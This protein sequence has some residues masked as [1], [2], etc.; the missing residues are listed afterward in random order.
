[1]NSLSNLVTIVVMIILIQNAFGQH[2]EQKKFMNGYKESL[3]NYIMTGRE[4]GWYDCDVLSANPI[5]SQIPQISMDL[6]EVA[7]L[8]EATIKSMFASSHCL[9]VNYHINSEASLSA[10]MD[11]GQAAIQH[12]RLAMIIDL[13]SGIT[14]NM[15]KNTTKIPYPVAAQLNNGLEFLCPVVGELV[16]RFDKKFCKASYVSFKHKTLRIALIGPMPEFILT[17][18]DGQIEGTGIGL[19]RM[20][21]KRLEFMPKIQIPSSLYAPVSMVC[22][23]NN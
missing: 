8:K 19:I 3:Q 13:K 11:F 4:K 14:L 16:P 22:Q 1:M 7:T 17:S 12:I 21:A 6:E 5:Y 2:Q 20:L 23:K 15:I 18:R 10:L 9:F